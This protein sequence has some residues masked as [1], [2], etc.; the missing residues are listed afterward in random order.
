MSEYVELYMDQGAD[1]SITIQ[2]NSEDNNLAQNL[3]GYVV[4]S[5]IRRSLISINATA[6]LVCT[7]PFANSGEVYIELDAGNTAN[8][9]AGTYFFDVKVNDTLAGLKSRLIEGVMFVTPSITR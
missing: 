6:N 5:S 7:I 4:T 1:F 8:I 2:I 9:P 3:A